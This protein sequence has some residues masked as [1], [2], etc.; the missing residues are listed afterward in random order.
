MVILSLSLSKEIII[1]ILINND[2]NVLNN[3]SKL[4]ARVHTGKQ[5]HK[6]CDLGLGHES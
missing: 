4:F 1:I 2:R 6:K 5:N 3:M